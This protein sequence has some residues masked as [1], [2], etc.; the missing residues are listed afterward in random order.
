MSDA[1]PGVQRTEVELD[2]SGVV[3]RAADIHDAGRAEL[4]LLP[5]VTYASCATVTVCDR[6]AS[7]RRIAALH[8]KKSTLI[9]LSRIKSSVGPVP[10][11]RRFAC[12]MC[13][14]GLQFQ[15]IGKQKCKVT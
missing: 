4:R 13:Y 15:V 5:G 10:K 3:V 6:A 9:E 11:P 7:G 14:P 12:L 2:E 1:R 8:N